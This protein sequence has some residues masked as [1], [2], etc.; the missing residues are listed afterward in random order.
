MQSLLVSNVAERDAIEER[1][2]ECWT[3]ACLQSGWLWHRGYLTDSLRVVLPEVLERLVRTSEVDAVSRGKTMVTTLTPET[4]IRIRMYRRGGWVRHLNRSCFLR[5]SLKDRVYQELSILSYL[6][7]TGIPVPEPIGGYV[8][9]VGAGMGYRAVIATR[10]ISGVEN[11][12]TQWRA[13]DVPRETV[14][15]GAARAAELSL[16]LLDAGV[17]H[18]DFHPGNLLGRVGSGEASEYF[19]IDLDR[20]SRFDVRHRAKIQAYVG[21][22]WERACL[23]HLRK[24][25]AAVAIDSFLR[26]SGGKT[27]QDG[28]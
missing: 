2:P 24:E 14:A 1:G 26:T 22:R 16:R 9:I 23:K 15:A 7:A 5:T 4:D 21:R 17:F 6:F 28:H 11:M 18:P 3:R 8:K 20:A 10:E 19:V 25:I 27:I 13:W 12:L